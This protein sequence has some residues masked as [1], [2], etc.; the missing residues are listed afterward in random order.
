MM[1]VGIDLE[2]FVTDP[3]TSGI[4][5]VLQYLAREWPTET[6]SCGFV[7]PWEDRYLLLSPEQASMLIDHAFEAPDVET[8]RTGVW[9]RVAEL[10]EVAPRVSA[11]NMLGQFDA[12]LMPEVSYLPRV[13]ERLAMVQESM[14][15]TMIGY[16][17]LPMTDPANYRFRPGTAAW[18]SEYFRRLSCA[19]SVVCISEYSRR[20]L[21]RRLRRNPGLPTSVAHPGGDHIPAAIPGVADAP[22]TGHAIRFLRVGTL[23]SRKMP[24]EVADAFLAA[25]R[26]GIDAHLTFIGRPSASDARLNDSVR[27]A[28][29]AD[30]KVDW[31][32]SATDADVR[33]ALRG[34]DIF[35]SVGTEGYGIPVL[36]SIRM[37]T[38]VLF[39]GI[40][41]AGELMAGRGARDVGD[42]SI[43]V[44]VEAFATYADATVAH[45]LRA[46]V[47]PEAVPRWSHF[48][49]AVA[50]ACVG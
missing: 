8:M 31:I 2:Q 37:G 44:L 46:E 30:P 4:Q 6:A 42:P 49:N 23:E 15:C 11:S 39:G 34:A 18:V 27:E 25:R 29:L 38:P 7:I 3:Y 13:L 10:A 14:P 35:L 17:A 32:E 1:H 22:S 33:R 50:R 16:D 12:W 5:R 36:E 21:L 41:P 26:R 47:D 43:E 9:M 24:R 45:S 28:C 20:A 19:T 48:T 40:Q